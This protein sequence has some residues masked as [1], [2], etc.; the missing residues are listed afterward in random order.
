MDESL[1]GAEKFTPA[2][3]PLPCSVA[4]G[5]CSKCV[6]MN[7]SP[8]RRRSFV[9]PLTK[10]LWERLYDEGY[11]A[12][13]YINTVNG[14]IIY[15]HSAILVSASIPIDF[16]LHLVLFYLSA[17]VNLALYQNYLVRWEHCRNGICSHFL[18]P[19]T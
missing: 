16:V 10:D 8:P 15:A 3:P 2:P 7:N 11:E 17:Y 12:D 6:V 5:C 14:G 19:I 18:V 4:A 9:S 13:V 1:L